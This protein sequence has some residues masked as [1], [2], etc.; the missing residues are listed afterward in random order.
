MA[1]IG[2]CV[3]KDASVHAL[4]VQQLGSQWARWTFDPSYERAQ[5]AYCKALGALGIKRFGT[6]DMDTYRAF[7]DP[8]DPATW[9]AAHQWLANT[10]PGYV[11]AINPL[12]EPD[13]TGDESST[14]SVNE[15]NA[16]LRIAHQEWP[17]S[18]KL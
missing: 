6:C 1:D 16:I 8:H 17:R 7:G 3:A 5:I 14:M 4:S 2:L 15:V 11:D 12:N 10:F 13:G 18:I 9:L